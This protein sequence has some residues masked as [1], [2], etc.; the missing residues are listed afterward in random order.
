MEI[1]DVINSVAV[2]ISNVGMRRVN[3]LKKQ[4]DLEIQMTRKQRK[5]EEEGLIENGDVEERESKTLGLT[6]SSLIN[7]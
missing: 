6:R 3:A 4:S 5:K 2:S 1:E 7:N